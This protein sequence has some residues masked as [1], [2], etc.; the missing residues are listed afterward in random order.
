MKV[1]NI[2]RSQSNDIVVND[3]LVSGIHCQIIKDNYG[4][5]TI[6]DTNSTN[7]TYVN[8][9]QRHGQ[10]GLNPNDIVRIGNTTLPWQ[11][12]FSGYDDGERT[13]FG[14]GGN[15]IDINIGGG[16]YQQPPSTKPDSFMVWAILS[17]I[18]CCLPF[19]IASIVNASKVDGLWAS[20]DY[21]GANEAARKARTWFWWA[22]ASGLISSII[23]VICYAV[24]GVAIGMGF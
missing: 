8:G 21:N 10:V 4:N 20:G 22:F 3:P 1:V 12:Y 2:G 23:Y 19:G 6:I 11:S 15:N 14:G 24:F 18:F 5:F 16:G 7:G 13:R 9:T 17:T